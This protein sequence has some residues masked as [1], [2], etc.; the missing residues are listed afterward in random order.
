MVRS[1]LS[2]DN[3]VEIIPGYLRLSYLHNTGVAFGLFDNVQ[4][5]W[6]PYILSA[7]AVIALAVIVYYSSRMPL[8]RKLLQLAL[9]IVMG[10]II[11]NFLDRVFRGYVIDFIEFH[12]QNRFYWPSFNFAD[13]AIT[14]GICLLLIDAIIHPAAEDAAERNAATDSANE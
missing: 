2:F 11:G 7:M 3:A 8:D 12:I 14:I 5:V 6:K 13:S 10:G 9:A 1:K 4:S